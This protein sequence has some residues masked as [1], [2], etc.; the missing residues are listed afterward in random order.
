[1]ADAVFES[2]LALPPGNG[3]TAVF[4]NS[5]NLGWSDLQE[6]MLV[7]PPG[8][9]GL[10]GIQIQYAVNPV[11]PAGPNGYYILDDYVLVIPVSNQQ[12]A[13]QWRIAGYNQDTFQHTVRSYWSYNF[14]PI[15]GQS[16][17]SSLVSL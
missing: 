7:F 13:G 2:D 5:V 10:V 1:M 12:Q 15:P 16:S 6:I 17:S 9:S 14:L 4:F 3:S 8:C 11:Y